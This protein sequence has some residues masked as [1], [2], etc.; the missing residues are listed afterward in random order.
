MLCVKEAVS[1]KYKA[2][3]EQY[4]AFHNF[5]GQLK[6]NNGFKIITM[7]TIN[8]WLDTN[9]ADKQIH[10]AFERIQ[11]TQAKFIMAHP[12]LGDYKNARQQIFYGF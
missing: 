8:D 7:A 6:T 2:M 5:I 12:K 4:N 9:K 3:L 10:G 11:S 1:R